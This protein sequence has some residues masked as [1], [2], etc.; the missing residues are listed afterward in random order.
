VAQ[1][2]RLIAHYRGRIRPIIDEL[3]PG[4]NPEEGGATDARIQAVKAMRAF[5]DFTFMIAGGD[6]ERVQVLER[7]PMRVYWKV[8]EHHL[9]QLLSEKKRQDRANKKTRYGR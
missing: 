6:V 9:T 5:D 7:G 2:I 1:A 8:A 4:T 3:D